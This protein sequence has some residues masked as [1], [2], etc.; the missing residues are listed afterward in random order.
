MGDSGL[1]PL[2][3]MFTARRKTFADNIE[4]THVDPS[5]LT[6]RCLYHDADKS[7]VSETN[8]VQETS[9]SAMVAL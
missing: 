3:R 4:Q 1:Q 8:D 5:S 6:V 2:T 7:A 9:P